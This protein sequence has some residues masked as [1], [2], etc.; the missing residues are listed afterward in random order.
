MKICF[1]TYE[2]VPIAKGGP[3]V[4]IL[5]TKK[6]LTK[7]GHE[8][9]LFNM[10]QTIDRL[11]DFDI[12]HLV[13]SN[14]SMYGLA[15]SLKFQNIKFLVEPVFYSRRSP[16]FLK[17]ISTVD[18]IN[19]KFLPGLWHDFSFVRDICA[20][21]HVVTPNT[22][23]ERDLIT[24]GFSVASNK[25][26]V[27]PNGVSELYSGAE[28]LLFKNT[29]GVSD[30]ILT[31]GH[32]GPKRK[33]MEALV[34]ALQQINHPSVIIG[35][36]L[37]TEE[38]NSVK[39]LLANSKNILWIDE[40]PYN[41][42]LLASAYAASDVFVLPSL[43][44]TPGIAALEAGLAGAKIVITPHGGTKE[45]FGDMAEYVDPYS[46][47]SI[48]NGIISALNRKKDT[49]LQTHIRK[50]F[51]WSKVAEKTLAVYRSAIQ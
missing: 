34:K 13:G 47:E 15:R 12:I 39:T 11:H 18:R 21:A 19:R 5:E 29:Y 35:K 46:V 23:A 31:V 1:A 17:V 42:P 10:W 16:S 41:S 36:M 22:T 9:E 45:Y 33:N 8:V 40:L 6:Q 24:K 20:W 4:K 49:A 37:D 32:I 3:Y 25:F 44:E 50:E 30:F 27:I 43:F 51:L 28:P 26:H 38:T 14:L 7:L 2:S 48:R